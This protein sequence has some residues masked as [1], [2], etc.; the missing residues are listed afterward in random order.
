MDRLSIQIQKN[1]CI[2]VSVSLPRFKKTIHKF[3]GEHYWEIGKTGY[4]LDRIT[5]NIKKKGFNIERT[6]RIFENLYHRFFILMKVQ[7]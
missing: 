4:P 3:D 2:K 6:Y 1:G 5:N 7:R